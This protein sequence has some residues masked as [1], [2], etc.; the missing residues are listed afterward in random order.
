MN[1]ER[2]KG[3]IDETV[4]SAKQEVGKVTGNTGTQVSGA[5]QQVKGKV[6]TAVGKA[7]DAVHDAHDNAVEQRRIDEDQTLNRQE[8]ARDNERTTVGAGSHTRH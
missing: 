3:A 8:N 7:K 1:K 6:E 4:G 2:V 5:V